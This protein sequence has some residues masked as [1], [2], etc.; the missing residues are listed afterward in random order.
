MTFQEYLTLN[1]S[2]LEE[3]AS[4]F[5]EEGK[6]YEHLTLIAQSYLNESHN[7]LGHAEILKQYLIPKQK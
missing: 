3:N 1:I 7:M 5:A 6:K 2:E 4:R